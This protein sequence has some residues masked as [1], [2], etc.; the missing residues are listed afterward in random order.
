MGPDIRP[1]YKTI[2]TSQQKKKLRVLIHGGDTDPGLNSFLGQNWTAGLGLTETQA[3]RPWTR[4]GKLKM[5]GYVT[6][7]EGNF[8]Y[9]T[10]RGSGHMVPEYK[11]EAAT[12]LLR[13][14]IKNEEYPR[15]VKPG[16]NQELT[17]SEDKNDDQV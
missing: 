1:W 12:V 11:P 14:F 15:F 4:D 8:D 7:Y 9:L 13:S 17:T 16:S 3:W 2:A 6:R 10:I 5:G